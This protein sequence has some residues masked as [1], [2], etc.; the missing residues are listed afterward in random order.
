MIDQS[1]KQRIY[2]AIDQEVDCYFRPE[3]SIHH[4]MRWIKRIMRRATE[5]PSSNSCRQA[6]IELV[7]AAS[8][9]VACL[10]QHGVV[11]R[12]CECEWWVY[13]TTSQSTRRSRRILVRCCQCDKRGMIEYPSTHEYRWAW[14]GCQPDGKRGHWHEPDRVVVEE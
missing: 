12:A 4:W 1:P 11:E 9:I 3:R 6:K 7:K 10:E 14:A 2:D 13:A 8:I 5:A